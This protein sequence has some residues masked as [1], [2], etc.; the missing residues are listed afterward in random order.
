MN[1]RT[2]QL[3][4]P[5]QGRSQAAAQSSY[6]AAVRAETTAPAMLVVLQHF[7]RARGRAGA[8]DAEIELELGWPPNI[9]TARRNELVDA[10]L[11]VVRWPSSRRPSVKPCRAGRAPLNVVV[12]LLIDCARPTGS[13]SEAQPC[14]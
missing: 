13:L 2:S 3:G 14:G 10:G 6:E 12:W 7:L 8:T 9:V 1:G 4:L 5:W 11:V